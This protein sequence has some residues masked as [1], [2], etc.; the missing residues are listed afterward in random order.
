MHASSAQNAEVET[1]FLSEI[2]DTGDI[3]DIDSSPW[4]V[5]AIRSGS[6]RDL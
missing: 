3:G 2:S 1:I 4:Q 5:V 6:I